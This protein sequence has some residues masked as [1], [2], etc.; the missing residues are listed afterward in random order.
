MIKH[1]FGDNVVIFQTDLFLSDEE[2]QTFK[3]M[4][5]QSF[6]DGYLILG[7]D[8]KIIVLD[9]NSFYVLRGEDL[10]EDDRL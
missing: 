1:N 10:K 5:E 3:R 6:E 8:W 7:C 9:K 2:I 4:I